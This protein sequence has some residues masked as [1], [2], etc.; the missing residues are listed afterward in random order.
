MGAAIQLR[1]DFDAEM[2]RKRARQN[3]DSVQCRRLRDYFEFCARA[4][5]LYPLLKR[6]SNRMANWFFASTH[7]RGGCFHASDERLRTRYS[8]FMAASLFGKCP[9]VRIALRSFEFSASIALVVYMIRRTSLGNAKN[10]MTCSQFRRQLSEIGGYFCPHSP[11]SNA[12]SASSA[13]SSSTAQ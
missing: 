9:R 8:S 1:A 4:F 5:S 6:S 13:A 12:S 7:P 11:S 3:R 2:L 10:G